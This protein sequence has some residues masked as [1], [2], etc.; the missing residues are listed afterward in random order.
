MCG[1]AGAMLS[2]K[3]NSKVDNV[4][5]IIDKIIF[6]QVNRGPDHQAL[7]QIN[8]ENLKLILGHNRLSIMDLLPSSNQPMWD[9]NKRFCIVY[10]GMLYNYIELRTQLRAVGYNFHT[11]G[12]T[13]VVLKAFMHWGIDAF[14]FFNGM[15][16]IV[17]FDLLHEKLYLVRDRFGIKPLF[18]CKIHNHIYFA[19]TTTELATQLKLQPNMAE[20]AR[21]VK[22]WTY[23]ANNQTLY[24]ELLSVAPS[25][26]ISI[27]YQQGWQ[28]T[29]HKFYSLEN[30]VNSLI[31]QLMI[32]SEK[33]LIEQ[34][35]AILQDAVS[36]RL[37]SDVPLGISL[38]GGID[39][40]IVASLAKKEQQDLIAFSFG[41][42]AQ[43][44]SEAKMTSIT[45][46]NIAIP[47]QF[48]F[49]QPSEMKVGFWKT[50][51]LQDAPFPTFSIVAQYFLFEA[52]NRQGIK[53]M[54]GGQGGDEIFMGYRKYLLFYCQQ[55]LKR[56]KYLVTLRLLL[57]LLPTCYREL[58]N[59]PKY[60]S[61]SKR[62]ALRQ[63]TPDRW[64]PYSTQI[65]LGISFNQPLWQRQVKDIY[66]YSL[67]ALLRYEDRNSMGNSIE[68]R[69]PFLDYRLVELA[70]ALPE[71]MKLRQGFGKWILRQVA[72]RYI[73][74]QVCFSRVK[75]GFDVQNRLWINSGIGESMRESLK[76]NSNLLRYMGLVDQVDSLFNDRALESNSAR[77]AECISLVWMSTKDHF[78]WN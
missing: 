68:T 39:S 49:P 73:P 69:L 16:A 11:K 20:I 62:Y 34:V 5:Q 19:S 64:K 6:S 8:S 59:F 58:G 56:R 33:K 4:T 57:G 15:F 23:G 28:M 78:N 26:V 55:L 18:Y 77:L 65:N 60:I 35:E 72:S 32:S 63:T 30:Q 9:E 27:Q 76:S 50:L 52:A 46:A 21:G 17:I 44:Y 67:P 53:V 66:A 29:T 40:A 75:R 43:N 7:T 22:Y 74:N 41:S 31:P 25:E 45:A 10:N 48:V 38:S 51:L 12:D 13:E 2:N 36:V 37:R 24:Q 71:A 1:I 42:L 54:L 14:N 47:L 3:E 70:L 61:Q